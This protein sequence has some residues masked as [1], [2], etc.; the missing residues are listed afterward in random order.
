LLDLALNDI[1]NFMMK[2]PIEEPNEL[3]EISLNA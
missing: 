1:N 3:E 2:N